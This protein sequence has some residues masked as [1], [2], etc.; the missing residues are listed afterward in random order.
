MSYIGAKP[1][2]TPTHSHQVFY[3]FKLD[4]TNGG[5]T[6]DVIDTTTVYLADLDY[7]DYFWSQNKVLY[8]WGTKGH[9]EVVYE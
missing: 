9:I 7:K 8:Q 2:D 4:I 5:L 6:V 3:G 1:E